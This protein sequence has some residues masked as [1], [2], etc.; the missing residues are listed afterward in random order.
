MKTKYQVTI[1]LQFDVTV[2]VMAENE[3]EADDLA[4]GLDLQEMLDWAGCA[5]FDMNNVDCM[6]R[7]Q[8]VNIQED[9]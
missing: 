1:N 5:S 2:P 7:V 6:L 4:H 9:F 3:D 8:V